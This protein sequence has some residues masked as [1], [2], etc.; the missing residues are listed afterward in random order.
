[1]RR[2][3]ANTISNIISKLWSTIAIY[4]FV[5]LYIKYLGETAYGLVSF[6]ATLQAAMNLLGLGLSN[7]LRREFAV[8]DTDDICNGTRKYKLLRS[9]ELIYFILAIIIFFICAFGSGFISSNWLNIESLDESLVSSVISLMGLSIALQFVANLYAGCLFGL[10]RQ[11]RANVY[12][13]GWSAFK[14]IGSLMII[15]FIKSDLALFY[16]WH[17]VSDILYLVI[18]RISILRNLEYDKN[19]KW[20]IHDIRNI[21]T[22]WKYATGILL[23]SFVALINK[24]L[25]K[26]I[27][28]KYLTLTELGAYNVA[29]TLGGLT[30]I[31][32]AAI[33]TSIFPR[34]TSMVTGTDGGSDLVNEFNIVNRVTSI[35]ISCLGAFIAL[36]AVPLIYIWTKSTVYTSALTTVGPLVVMAIA[37]IE[38]QEICYALALAH[39]NTKI[40]VIVGVVFIPVIAI[41]TWLGIKNFGLMGAAVVYIIA[42]T[43]QTFTYQYLVLKRYISDNPVKLIILDTVVPILLAL[44]LAFFSKYLIEKITGSYV[45]QAGLA[46]LSGG[47]ALCISLFVLARKELSLIVNKIR[48]NK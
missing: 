8:G 25:D 1:M 30:T 21:E 16:S 34:F 14:S 7:T 36:F 47:L 20:N 48:K 43:A 23:I 2:L 15:I 29:T 11:V 3:G 35:F 31:I 45:L 27:I 19:A 17:I 39:G 37:M 6:F 13:V 18:L 4:L 41:T 42:M 38:Y 26:V 33:Y 32:P 40:N 9:T 12:C 28:S 5:P 10:E 44:I 24:Q 22:I 46:V